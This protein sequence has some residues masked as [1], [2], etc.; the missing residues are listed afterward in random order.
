[1]AVA[2][3]SPNGDYLFWHWSPLYAWRINHRL[4]G[5][6]E[7]MITYLLAMASPAHQVPA[8]MYYSGWASK[9]KAAADY[10]QTWSGS[11]EGAGYANGNTCH[12]IKLAVGVGSGGPLFFAHYS[13]L[14]FDLHALTDLYTN[15][16]VN[17]RNMALINRIYSIENPNGYPG[18]G[19]RCWGLTASAGPS[20][21]ALSG[22]RSCRT[23]KSDPC[24]SGSR[25]KPAGGAAITEAQPRR[26]GR[27]AAT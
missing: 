11:G 4:I 13:Y 1:M 3:R 9:G 14:G 6:N 8:T 7:T 5:F 26:A 19:G 24:W 12:G 17:N 27:L 25:W 15:Y 21:R 23:L 2:R 16:F 18:Y 20:G 10:R 22:S